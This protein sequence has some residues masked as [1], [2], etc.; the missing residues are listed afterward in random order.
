MSGFPAVSC[1][2]KN[3][4]ANSSQPHNLKFKSEIE[5]KTSFNVLE[6]HQQ[7]TWQ[8][9]KAFSFLFLVVSSRIDLAVKHYFWTKEDFF[10]GRSLVLHLKECYMCFPSNLSKM[11]TSSVEIFLIIFISI[12]GDAPLIYLVFI[13]N[14]LNVDDGDGDI[15]HRPTAVT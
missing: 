6:L 2:N 9:R 5:N 4:S 8:H 14:T 10:F 11:K 7:W 13:F 12:S 1:R 3:A 15:T